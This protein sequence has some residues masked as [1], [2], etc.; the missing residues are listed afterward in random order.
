[1]R[2]KWDMV[3]VSPVVGIDLPCNTSRTSASGRIRKKVRDAQ[4]NR[5]TAHS[6]NGITFVSS[7]TLRVGGIPKFSSV[8]LSMFPDQM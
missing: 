4:V 5:N 3:S 2:V 1:M 6:R 7:S 8:V